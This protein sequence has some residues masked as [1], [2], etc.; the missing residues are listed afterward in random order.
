MKLP[1]F[2]LALA[3]VTPAVAQDTPL[4]LG[5]AQAQL[6]ARLSAGGAQPPRL[7]VPADAA[8]LRAANDAS[9]LHALDP[10]DMGTLFQRCAGPNTW[11]VSYMLWGIQAQPDA[12]IAQTALGSSA[13]TA[14]GMRYQDEIAMILSATTAC[15]KRISLSISRSL[16]RLPVEQRVSAPGLSTMRAGVIN[17]LVGLFEVQADPAVRPPNKALALSGLS[18][19][20]AESFLLLTAAQRSVVRR[21]LAKA[22]RASGVANR[23]ALER[24]AQVMDTTPCVDTCLI[25]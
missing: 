8:L 2:L 9:A 13:A 12:Q 24:L 6:Q 3:A 22:I 7:S 10:D 14:N 1:A 4:D 16:M 21:A 5:T 20:P 11:V 18:V 15:S 23:A 25:P 19:E 17:L